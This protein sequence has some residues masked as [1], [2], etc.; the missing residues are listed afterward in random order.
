[1]N[2]LDH[3]E[4]YSF[5]SYL[6]M[7]PITRSYTRKAQQLHNRLCQLNELNESLFSYLLVNQDLFRSV[8][9]ATN[10]VWKIIDAKIDPRHVMLSLPLQKMIEEKILNV[11]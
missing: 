8:I 5:H 6:T 4:R 1:M 2:K 10:N 9:P 7:A 3:V 11:D